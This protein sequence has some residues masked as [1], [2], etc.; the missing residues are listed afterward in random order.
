MTF[1]SKIVQVWR[2]EKCKITVK[3]SL[4][5]LDVYDR[6][7]HKLKLIE[8]EPITKKPLKKGKK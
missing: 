5:V 4:P 2:C 7:G 8:G 3:Q 1:Q 6:Q